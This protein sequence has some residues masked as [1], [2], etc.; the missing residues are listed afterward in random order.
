MMNYRLMLNLFSVSVAK[1]FGINGLLEIL[2]FFLRVS[3]FFYWLGGCDMNKYY[4]SNL[5]IEIYSDY[6]DNV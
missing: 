5:E 6:I 4:R 3:K 1:L 2:N